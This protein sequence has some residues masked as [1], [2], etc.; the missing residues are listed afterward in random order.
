M[1]DSLKRYF[2]GFVLALLI[3]AFAQFLGQNYGAPPMLFAL[4]I[5]IAFSFLYESEGFSPGISWAGSFVLR[6][7]VALL[8]LRLSFA[9]LAALGWESA[10]LIFIAI[11]S[12]I[13][14]GRLLAPV[15]GIAKY[16]GV[17]TGGAVAIC[18]ASAAMAISSILPDHKDKDRDLSVTIIGITFLST[19]AM[20]LYPLIAEIFSLDVRDSG[21]FLGGTIHDVAQVVGAG[22][23]V[24]DQTGDIATLTKLARVSFL[25]P[26]VVFLSFYLKE[27]TEIGKSSVKFP[28]FLLVFIAL[29]VMNSFF[30]IPEI[31]KESVSDFSRFALIVAIGAIGLKS[32]L[33]QIVSVGL[34]PILLI[35]VET[36]WLA[37][38]VL[39]FIHFV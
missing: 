17:L 38:V 9:D 6:M 22:Y 33:K 24:S 7:G 29:M 28:P 18:G 12:T 35:V 30:Q 34:R 25:V 37:G 15:L 19:V 36:L 8:G 5:G 39:V 14:V 16:F 1:A 23:S 32:N 4:L 13:F 10:L 11:V 26:V 20:V 21:V 27:R 2:Y 31:M 3:G